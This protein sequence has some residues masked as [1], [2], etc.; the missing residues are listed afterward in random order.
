M[1]NMSIEEAVNSLFLQCLEN[2]RIL[3]E[4][5]K[6]ILTEVTDG[7]NDNDNGVRERSEVMKHGSNKNVSI[8]ETQYEAIMSKLEEIV[9]KQDEIHTIVFKTNDK[10]KKTEILEEK[11]KYTSRVDGD[12]NEWQKEKNEMKEIMDRLQNDK[13]SLKKQLMDI[14]T[15]KGR[16]EEEYKKFKELYEIEKNKLEDFKELQAIW[17]ELCDLSSDNKSYLESLC[18]S[19]DIYATLSLGRD[20]GK[21]EQLWSCIRD[22]AVKAISDVEELKKMNRYFE[23]CIDVANS[24][25]KINDKYMMFDI[26]NGT[27]YDMETSIRT[28]DSRQIGLIESM[29]VKGVKIGKKIRF[30]AVVRVK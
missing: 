26:D 15:E 6:R 14:E 10:E 12:K 5:K 16:Y 24:T 20:D 7:Q 8:D 29:L 28:S 4:L 23:F 11:F 2:P 9:S 19:F 25:K 13:Q 1:D 17:E 30:K 21:I 3:S 18:G 27:E 22:Q